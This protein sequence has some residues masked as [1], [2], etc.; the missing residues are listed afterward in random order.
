MKRKYLIYTILP[1]VGL[2]LLG[3]G[4]ASACGWF[5][6]FGNLDPDKVAERQQTMFQNQAQTLGIST[7][8]IKEAWAEGKTIKEIME[9]KGITEEQVRARMKELQLEQMKSYL[10]VLVEKGI[11]T[12][13]QADKRL[14]TVQ[15]QLEN[16]KMGKMGR[17]FHMGM[18]FGRGFSW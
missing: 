12:Q 17:G 11:I 13:V 1:V 4:I 15:S 2:A 18:G 10:Q 14:E 5:G 9:E 8:E 6:G 3:G 16:G 7:D